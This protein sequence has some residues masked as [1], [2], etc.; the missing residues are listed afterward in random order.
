MEKIGIIAGSGRFPILVAEEARRQGLEVVALGLVGVTD[1]AVEQAAGNLQLFKLGQISKPIDIFKAAGVTKAVMAGKVQHASL[2][3]GLMPDLRAV[4]L[5]A[6][7]K[8]KRT[9]TILSA[10]AEEFKKDG[11]ELLPTHIYLKHLL[12]TDGPMTKRAPS[13][14]EA[15]DIRLGWRC[16]KALAGCDVGQTVVVKDGAVIAVEAMEGT[17]Q[18]ILRARDLARSQGAKP[19]LTVVKVAKPKQDPRFDLPVLG[20]DSLKTFAEAGVSAV[21]LQSG[22][23]LIFDKD[24]FL[25]DAD[26]QGIAL[27]GFPEEGPR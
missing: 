21:A 13:A 7:L 16:A 15:A 5:L 24:Q 18:T 22:S 27:A 10:V 8:D 6:R 11:I 4:K 19:A 1:P 23:T 25:K 2:F 17:D 3:G 26:A 14:S 12:V 9:D 20:L